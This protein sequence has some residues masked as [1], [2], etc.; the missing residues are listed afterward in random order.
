MSRCRATPGLSIDLGLSLAMTGNYAEA[1]GILRPLATAVTSSPRERQT[2][3]LIY[4]LQGDRRAA[5]Q[6]ARLD[7][8]PESARRNLAY[9]D[10]LRRLSPEARQRAILSLG[11]RSAAKAVAANGQ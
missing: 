11:T 6:M 7:L 4:G 1:V 8:D 2:L 3:A 5:E 10:G 9:Y